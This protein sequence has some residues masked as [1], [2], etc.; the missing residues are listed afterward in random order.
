MAHPRF[1]RIALARIAHQKC[2][3][4]RCRQNTGRFT[5]HA[6]RHCWHNIDRTRCITNLETLAQ[7]RTSNST[8]G[9]RSPGF[10]THTALLCVSYT[11]F[12]FVCEKVNQSNDAQTYHENQDRVLCYLMYFTETVCTQ[13]SGVARYIEPAGDSTWP[14]ADVA[15]AVAVVVSP[16]QPMYVPILWCLLVYTFIDDVPQIPRL[17]TPRHPPRQAGAF[18]TLLWHQIA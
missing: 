3:C 11:S 13:H 10:L 17:A 12:M 8:T 18:K 9:A 6:R 2:C 14:F 15:P 4:F 1:C 16:A 7:I 5:K